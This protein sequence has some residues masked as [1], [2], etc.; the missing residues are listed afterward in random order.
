MQQ[1]H[2]LQ[3]PQ[4]LLKPAEPK[5]C[6]AGQRHGHLQATPGTGHQDRVAVLKDKN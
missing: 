4:R 1:L 6:R 2:P 5:V 3:L